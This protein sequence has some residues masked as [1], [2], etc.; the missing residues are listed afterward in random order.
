[1][2]DFRLADLRL[3]HDARVWMARF[4]WS[5]A[6]NDMFG[7]CHGMEIAFLFWK[8]GQTGGF[9]GENEAPAEVA[10]PMQ[11]AWVAFARTGDPNCES[12]PPW[13]RYDARDRAVMSIDTESQVVNDPD[14]IVRTLWQNIIL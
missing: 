9:L 3:Q 6:E 1:M 5:S 14:G 8:P 7:A 12:L 4:S 11:D 2:P 10:F 13:P